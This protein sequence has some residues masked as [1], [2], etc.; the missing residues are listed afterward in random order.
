MGGD[1]F[2]QEGLHLAGSSTTQV[3]TMGLGAHCPGGT[4][5]CISEVEII[6]ALR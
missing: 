2:H 1:L 4:D 3:T 6:S 5:N